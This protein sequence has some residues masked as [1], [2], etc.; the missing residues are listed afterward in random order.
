MKR[1]KENEMKESSFSEIL[2]L[3]FCFYFVQFVEC[4]SIIFCFVFYFLSYFCKEENSFLDC[5][6]VTDL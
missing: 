2:F 1:E 4:E 3:F 6:T 5:G